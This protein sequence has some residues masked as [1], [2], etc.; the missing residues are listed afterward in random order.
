MQALHAGR[1]VA[2]AEVTCRPECCN[3][4]NGPPDSCRPCG[5]ALQGWR[6]ESA[7]PEQ[8][9]AAQLA[10]AKLAEWL[11]L[12]HTARKQRTF[13]AGSALV[14]TGLG[15]GVGMLTC[16]TSRTGTGSWSGAC[17]S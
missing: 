16:G 8:Q 1:H 4:R 14:P 17:S 2:A 11:E 5:T 15:W 13:Q 7:P 3:V 6:Y 9:Q 10:A 12:L